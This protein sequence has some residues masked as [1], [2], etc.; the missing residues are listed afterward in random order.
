M[1]GACSAVRALPRADLS[2]SFPARPPPPS[3]RQPAT[4]AATAGGAGGAAP[5]LTAGGGRARV[6]AAAPGASRRGGREAKPSGVP[7]GERGPRRGS[8]SARRESVCV[9]GVDEPVRSSAAPGFPPGLPPFPPAAAWHMRP[10]RLPPAPLPGARRHTGSRQLLYPPS[11]GC[12]RPPASQALPSPRGL[13]RSFPSSH[14]HSPA[15]ASRPRHCPRFP[16]LR[17]LGTPPSPSAPRTPGRSPRRAGPVTHRWRGAETD[18]SARRNRSPSA[19]AIFL[20]L[21]AAPHSGGGSPGPAR[22]GGGGGVGRWGVGGAPGLLPANRRQRCVR[23]R[24]M[25][26]GAP[27]RDRRLPAAWPVCQR[28]VCAARG[29]SPPP[30]ESGAPR[31]PPP[32]PRPSARSPPA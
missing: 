3:G 31:P 13:P 2:P 27:A 18:R 6:S 15:A 1:I 19:A 17:T 9:G 4:A 7:H 20:F 8:A 29:E 25:A 23:R 12:P 30:D 26:A 10:R 32:F 24:P 11:G 28:S 21:F 14:P 22:G 16:P 5:R